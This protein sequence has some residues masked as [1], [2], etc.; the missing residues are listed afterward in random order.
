MQKCEM[1]LRNSKFEVPDTG[2]QMLDAEA[3]RAAASRP[4]KGVCSRV[5]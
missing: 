3:N 5:E 2:Y 4:L 1:P